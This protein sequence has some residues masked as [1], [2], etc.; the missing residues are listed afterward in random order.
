MFS[1][2]VITDGIRLIVAQEHIAFLE[3]LAERVAAL[4]LAHPTGG[5]A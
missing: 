1:Y 5:R 2:D 3:T 4:V